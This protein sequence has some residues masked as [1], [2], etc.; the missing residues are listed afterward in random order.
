MVVRGKDYGAFTHLSSFPN[1]AGRY[2]FENIKALIK[3]SFGN[4]KG[5]FL[6][7]GK[8][9]KIIIVTRRKRKRIQKKIRNNRKN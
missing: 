4:V 5:F 8:L 1:F 7:L 9:R 3:I 2:S 6:I